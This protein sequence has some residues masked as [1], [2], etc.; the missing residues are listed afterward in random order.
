MAGKVTSGELQALKDLRLADLLC[1]DRAIP[2]GFLTSVVAL[3]TQVGE[4]AL[5]SASTEVAAMF[6]ECCAT[7]RKSGGF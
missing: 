3:L 2:A 6:V 1:Q 5:R 7:V 4:T